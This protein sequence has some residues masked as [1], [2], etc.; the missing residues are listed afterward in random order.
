ME[1]PGPSSVC[2]ERGRQGDGAAAHGGRGARPA[3]TAA[4]IRDG[5]LHTGD[6]A[7]IDAEGYVNIVDRKQDRIITG[8]ENV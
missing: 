3:E 4:A 6:L 5:W 7:T 8:G 1:K 2:G